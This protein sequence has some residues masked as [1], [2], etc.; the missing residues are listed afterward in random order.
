MERLNKKKLMK[1]GMKRTVPS[2]QELTMRKLINHYIDKAIPHLTKKGSTEHAFYETIEEL[3][4]FVLKQLRVE[5]GISKTTLEG[6][7]ASMVAEEAEKRV[8]DGR[9]NLYPYYPS[10]SSNK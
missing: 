1:G 2:L 4:E 5:E 7:I 10:S 6:D 3:K 9:S 8:R